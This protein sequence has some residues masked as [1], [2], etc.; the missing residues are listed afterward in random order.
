MNN[1][2]C[3]IQ[4]TIFSSKGLIESVLNKYSLE[5]P[6]ECYFFKQGVNDTYI[7]RDVS[8]NYYFRVYKY[9]LRTKEEIEAEIEYLND[10]NTHDISVSRPIK[11][12]EGNYLNPLQAPEGIRYAVLFTE[13]VGKR[14]D[15]PSEEENY[16]FGNTIA[17]MHNIT[18]KLKSNY[19]RFHI[20][21]KHLVD[22]PL[23][24]MEPYLKH[25]KNDYEYLKGI[26]EK[27]KAIIEETLPKT[28]PLYGVCHGDIHTGNL[29]F[30][31]DGSLTIFDFDCCGY[32]WRA[33]EIAVYRWLQEINKHTAKEDNPKKL[34]WDKFLEGYNE[35]RSLSAEEIE[36]VNVFVAIRH[37]WTMGLHTQI[38]PNVGCFFIDDRYFDYKINVIKEWIKNNNIC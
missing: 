38:A 30:K 6:I 21:L 4:T 8:N 5:K 11:N 7:V 14:N 33:Y 36:A 9:D 23:M 10:L 15:N 27:L 31:D 17:R 19:K 35:V 32:G 12:N 1:E 24:N 37:I 26:G 3:P 20:D 13:A 28:E 18:D 2:F 16:N 22:E 29:N 25:R 34:Q